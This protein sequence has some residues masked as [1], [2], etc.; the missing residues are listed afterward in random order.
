MPTD[1]NATDL[2]E[3]TTATLGGTEQFVMFD[4]VQGKRA[5]LNNIL[6]Y[7]MNQGIAF[8]S[9]DVQD[10]DASEWTSVTPIDSGNIFSVIFNRISTMMKNVRF[11]WKLI[12]SDSFSNVASTL[13][14]AIGNTALTTTAQTLSGAIVEHESDI[15]ALNSKLTTT[16]KNVQYSK[17]YTLGSGAS[18]N[19]TA[20]DFNVST[21]SGYT[22]V[23]LAYYSSGNAYV[24]VRGVNALAY[25]TTNMMYM[26]NTHTQ[27]I[28][29]TAY[30]TVLYAKTGIV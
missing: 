6:Q 2:E 13:S 10:E 23:G 16:L 1:I 21:P 27:E 12:G 29:A 4:A 3:E 25:G 20:D 19:L 17:A 28:S 15:S 24:Y 26:R 22:A 5:S 14:G 18:L 11:L 7:F 8:T 9:N 30:M